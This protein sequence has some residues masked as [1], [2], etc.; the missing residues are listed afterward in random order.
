M[1]LCSSGEQVA[2]C[3]YFNKFRCLL[4]TE[5]VEINLPNFSTINDLNKD[6]LLLYCLNSNN[7]KHYF[8][9]HI[10]SSA[11][12]RQFI[13]QVIHAKDKQKFGELENIVRLFNN[14]K[15]NYNRSTITVNNEF[16]SHLNNFNPLVQPNPNSRI[17]SLNNIPGLVTTDELL[18]GLN[19]KERRIKRKEMVVSFMREHLYGRQESNI[20]D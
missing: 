5:A 9:D 6:A 11:V 19:R 4:N 20:M 17:F 15:S 7:L 1:P 16:M 18:E 14:Y 3:K 13:L 10:S 8:P 2:R 12:S